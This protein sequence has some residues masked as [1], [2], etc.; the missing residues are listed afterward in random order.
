MLER[1]FDGLEFHLGTSGEVGDGAVFD[2]AVLAEGLA[3][4][5]AVVGFAVDGG[6][7][8]VEIHSEHTISIIM[9]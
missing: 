1:Q 3:E 4:E 2:F 9:Q 8:A 6:M 7:G 5:D